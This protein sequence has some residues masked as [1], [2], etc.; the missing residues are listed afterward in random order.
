MLNNIILHVVD[1]VDAEPVEFELDEFEQPPMKPLD[2]R[3]NLKVTIRHNLPLW[4]R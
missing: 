1:V 2:Q 4:L 3:D